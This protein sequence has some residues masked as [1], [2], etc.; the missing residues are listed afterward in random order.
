MLEDLI[1]ERRLKLERYKKSADPY[2]AEVKRTTSIKGAISA[3]VKLEKSKKVLWL[4]GRI[5]ALR[6][7]GGIIFGDL[8]D[9]TGQIQIILKKEDVA[10]FDLL[11]ETLDIGDFM[12]AK[13]TLLKT[14]RGEKSIF[15]KQARIISKSLRPLPQQWYGLENIETRLRKRYLDTLLNQEVR[16]IFLKKSVFWDSARGFLKKEGFLEVETPVFENLPGGAEAEPFV[17]HHN[18]LDRD[19]FLRI[20][21]ELPLKKIIIGGYEKVFEIGR[22]FRN[23]GIDPEHLQDYTQLE[24]YWA[25]A[26]YKALIKLIEKMYKFMVKSTCGT[27]K[28][29]SRGHEVDWSKKWKTAD[30]SELFEKTAGLNPVKATREELTAKAK[31]LKLDFEPNAGRGR[32]IDLIYK[33]SIRPFIIEPTLLINHP[34][35]ISPLAKRRKENPETTERVQVLAYGS[36]LGNGWS[37]LNDPVDQRKRFEEQMALR[38]K[39]DKEAQYLDEEFLEAMEYGMPPAAGFGMS[40]RLFAVLMDKPIRETVF[41]PL[42]RE[43]K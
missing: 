22:V 38:A 6:V 10:D 17:T 29:K 26:D 20:S 37:E 31:S 21:L 27:M 13:G 34:V 25:Y 24:F 23:E 42:M 32:L 12:E 7:Q 43:E 1:R 39:G 30:Y 19:F 18:A 41:F 5:M 28:V 35:S 33:K 11:K 15:A 9:E 4:V 3:F 36:E 8:K 40:E 2:P 14:K 16:D